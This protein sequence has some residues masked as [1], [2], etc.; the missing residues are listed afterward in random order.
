MKRLNT[1]S[2]SPDYMRLF[3]WGW[4]LFFFLLGGIVTLSH[5]HTRM[6]THTHRSDSPT[7]TPGVHSALSTSW[8]CGCHGDRCSWILPPTV[9][10]SHPPPVWLAQPTDGGCSGCWSGSD[11]THLPLQDTPGYPNLSMPTQHGSCTVVSE[12][13]GT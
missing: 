8:V 1:W 6:H 4:W 13:P 2:A 7:L 12:P 10:P 3:P 11:R 5:T 9:P